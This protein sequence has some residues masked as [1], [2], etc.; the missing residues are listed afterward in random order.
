MLFESKHSEKYF[1]KLNFSTNK[2]H[3][4]IGREKKISK[5][6]QK[7]F[8][9]EYYFVINLIK[10]YSQNEILG[11]RKKSDEDII[12]DNTFMDD[13][14]WTYKVNFQKN[15]SKSAIKKAIK[16]IKFNQRKWNE[17]KSRLKI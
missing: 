3:K 5:D 6:L 8:F 9:V 2:K 4:K 16:I 10:Y 12:C 14:K 1:K 7:S 11:K 17:L 13:K 15:G